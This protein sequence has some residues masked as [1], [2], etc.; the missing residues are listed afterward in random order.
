MRLFVIGLASAAIFAV[1]H[2]QAQD[3]S[4]A[5]K[6]LELAASRPVNWKSEKARI[7]DVTCDGKPDTIM[8]GEAARSVWLGVVPGNGDKPQIMAFAL[9]SHKQFQ[10]AFDHRP[11]KVSL[12]PLTCDTD[13]YGPLAGCRY[14][15]NCQAFSLDN[16]GTD[17][18][19][20]YWDDL[21][22]RF[23]WWRN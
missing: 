9:S 6:A 15:K 2:S 16:G 5:K 23:D 21:H 14:V 19:N 7:A 22:K 12:Y 3:F 17:P 10:D 13:I 8:F 4:A 18:F 11:T 1:G 20:F